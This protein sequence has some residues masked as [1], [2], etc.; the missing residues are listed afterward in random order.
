[1]QSW[2]IVK[3]TSTIETTKLCIQ[4]FLYFFMSLQNGNKIVLCSKF[5]TKLLII[6]NHRS[7]CNRYSTHSNMSY[8]IIKLSFSKSMTKCR[9]IFFSFS[10]SVEW[11]TTKRIFIVYI[12]YILYIN[13]LLFCFARTS[14]KDETKFSINKLFLWKILSEDEM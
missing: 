7:N 3:K 2:N 4:V 14:G 6:N 8:F 10:D 11:L 9:W 13:Y 1:M 5:K 12:H